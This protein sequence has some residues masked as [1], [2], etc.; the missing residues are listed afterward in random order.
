MRACKGRERK[1]DESKRDESRSNARK[2][3]G[4]QALL[5]ACVSRPASHVI[6]HVTRQ[7]PRLHYRLLALCPG[8]SSGPQGQ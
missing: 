1:R 5:V 8:A 6:N 3:D 2:P 7:V 4:S